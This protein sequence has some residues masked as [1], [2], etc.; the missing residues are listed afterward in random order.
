MQEQLET[1]EKQQ[2]AKT[3]PT[4]KELAEMGSE[5][6]KEPSCRACKR[7][8]AEKAHKNRAKKVEGGKPCQLTKTGGAIWLRKAGCKGTAR[9]SASGL[10]SRS[11]LAGFPIKGLKLPNLP[12]TTSAGEG[13]VIIA[14]LRAH[15]ASLCRLGALAIE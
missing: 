15:Y 12:R 3:L 10:T 14:Q 2:K 1:H 5:V 11:H 13:D 8:Q 4:T 9:A 7:Y 6:N